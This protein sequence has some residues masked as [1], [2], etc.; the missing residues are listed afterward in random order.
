[1]LFS[2]I[3]SN[4][5]IIVIDS[6]WKIWV[7]VYLTEHRSTFFY[8]IYCL[9]WNCTPLGDVP[10]PGIEPSSLTSPAL[11]VRFFTTGTTCKTP[12]SITIINT[13]S[14]SVH[15]VLSL[16]KDVFSDFNIKI[17][18]VFFAAAY[19]H[20]YLVPILLMTKWKTL[21]KIKINDCSVQS[22][23]CV[24]LF[25]TLWTAACQASLSI[26]NSWSLFKLLYIESVMP[27]NH[28]ILLSSPSPPA[29]SL[30]QHQELF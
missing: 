30:S 12:I 26:T 21:L 28:L 5:I 2:Y 6:N 9:L 1:M 19:A 7:S 27:S 24:R 22:L 23:S 17:L 25:V 10:N 16:A 29:F 20:I 3:H 14:G 15:Q 8:Y 4:W 11:A 18:I 13:L